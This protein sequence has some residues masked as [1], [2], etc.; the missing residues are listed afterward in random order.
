MHP[1]RPGRT[2]DFGRDG[3]VYASNKGFGFGATEG[4]IGMLAVNDSD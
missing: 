3:N 2:A 4:E 1:L